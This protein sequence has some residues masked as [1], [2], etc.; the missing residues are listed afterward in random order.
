MLEPVKLSDQMRQAM[1]S[2]GWS[3]YRLALES[4]VA[5]SVI[6][7]F[8]SGSALT[9]DTLDRL[10]PV[11]GLRIDASA[12]RSAKAPTHKAT[13]RKRAHKQGSKDQR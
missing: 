11:I 2:G 7:R 5:P 10:A 8:L 3:I 9:T 6:S 1:R 13:K 12:I 4:G